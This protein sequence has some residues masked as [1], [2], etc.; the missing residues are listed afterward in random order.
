MLAYHHKRFVST[1]SCEGVRKKSLDKVPYMV[2]ITTYDRN[3]KN[4]SRK[5]L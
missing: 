1:V 5:I 3:L 2:H 4:I